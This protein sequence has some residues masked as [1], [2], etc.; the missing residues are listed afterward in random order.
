MTSQ[1]FKLWAQEATKLKAVADKAQAA[2]ERA[3]AE[4]AKAQHAFDNKPPSHRTGSAVAL[5]GGLVSSLPGYDASRRLRDVLEH[6]NRQADLARSARD[7]ARAAW[8][9]AQTFADTPAAYDAATAEAA[10]AEKALA[11]HRSVL[12]KKREAAP[13]LKVEAEA[14][15][16]ALAKALDEVAAAVEAGDSAAVDRLTTAV[17]NYTA[18]DSATRRARDQV[19]TILGLGRDLELDLSL[20]ARDAGYKKQH[21]EK[22]IHRASVAWVFEQVAPVLALAKSHGVNPEAAL[23]E[24][25]SVDARGDDPAAQQAAADAVLAKLGAKGGLLGMLR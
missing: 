1:V 18:R 14:A 25:A 4:R 3:E 21:C 9:R 12:A 5:D 8:Q 10:S 11:E 22:D 15:A 17:A 2:Y 6:A 20:K 16:A 7:V 13:R 23:R 19:D 24:V